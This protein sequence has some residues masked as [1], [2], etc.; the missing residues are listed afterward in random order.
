MVGLSVIIYIDMVINLPLNILTVEVFFA[1]FSPMVP[2]SG[3]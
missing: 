1:G 3:K 2:D